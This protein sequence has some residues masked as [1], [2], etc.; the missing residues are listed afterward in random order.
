MRRYQSDL[1]DIGR[2]LKGNAIDVDHAAL[3]QGRASAAFDLASQAQRRGAVSTGQYR[4]AYQQL[5]F[6]VQEVTPQ[7][8]L[9]INPMVVL[10]QQGAQV[11]SALAL[12]GGGAATAARRTGG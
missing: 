9:A 11:A 10:A 6:Q 8:A 12:R 2:L 7:T 3:L 5:G 1:A 4:A